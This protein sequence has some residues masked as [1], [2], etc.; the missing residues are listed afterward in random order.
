MASSMYSNLTAVLPFD[1]PLFVE[2]VTSDVA[3][4]YFHA[5]CRIRYPICLLNPV[6]CTA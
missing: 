5:F 1:R 6:V 3:T 4:S 2:M